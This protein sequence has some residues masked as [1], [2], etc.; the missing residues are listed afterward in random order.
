ME[1][2]NLFLDLLQS[3]RVSLFCSFVVCA[4]VRVRV[5]FF[6]PFVAQFDL[7][8]FSMFRNIFPPQERDSS[9]KVDEGLSQSPDVN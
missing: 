9:F 1:K 7:C 2:L 5:L 3:Y 6:G 8:D 4:C